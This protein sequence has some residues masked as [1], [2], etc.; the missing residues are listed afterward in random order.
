MYSYGFLC[1]PMVSCGFLLNFV[2][3]SELSQLRTESARVLW[4]P[5][6]PDATIP[7]GFHRIPMGSDAF[8]RMGLDSCRTLGSS[9][10]HNCRITPA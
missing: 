2:G 8:I 7:I 6:D 4:I 10:P 5:M 3:F 1:I 9:I